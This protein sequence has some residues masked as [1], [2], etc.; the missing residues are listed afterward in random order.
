M[1]YSMSQK[2]IEKISKFIKLLKLLS[3]FT[4]V[5]S[6]L[7]GFY[8]YFN[9]I[10]APGLGLILSGLTLWLWHQ[11]K[12]K[13]KLPILT[14]GCLVLLIFV[15]TLEMVSLFFQINFWKIPESL[16]VNTAITFV[17]LSIALLLLVKNFYSAAQ[18]F[19]VMAFLI[20][21]IGFLG[22]VYQIKD[23]Y[24]FGSYTIM[25]LPT[26]IA[27]VLLSL[28]IL[29][30]AP[31]HGWIRTFTS[32]NAGGIMARRM[33]PIAIAMPLIV[34]WLILI[35]YRSNSYSPEIAITLSSLLN[36]IFF[37]W[38]IWCTAR[39]L[40]RIDSQR[41]QVQKAL[42]DN[43]LKF[44]AI[45]DQSFQFVALLQPNGTLIE[46]NQAALDFAGITSSDVVNKPF[47]QTRWWVEEDRL[48]TR[49]SLT[50]HEDLLEVQEQ[51][52]TA[53]KEAAKGALVRYEV[54]VWGANNQAA[55]IDFSLKPLRDRTGEVILL[56]AEGR[57]ISDRKQF[58][59]ALREREQFLASIYDGVNYI[60]CVVDVAE[61]GNIT[62]AGWNP[63]TEKIT[64]ISSQAIFGK[65]PEELFPP[66][67][68]NEFRQG[69]NK[70]LAAKASISY[71]SCT[72][73]DDEEVWLM[74][75]L[76]PLKDQA[77]KI[78]RIIATSTYITERKKAEIALQNSEAQF[79]KLAQQEALINR[80]A[81]QIRNSLDIDRILETTVNEARSLLQIDRAAF[82]W[83]H[84]DSNPQT[85]ECIKEA[86]NDL[87]P[88]ILGLY[89]ATVLGPL[90]EKIM[91]REIFQVDEVRTFP[92]PILREFLSELRYTSI[93]ILPIQTQSGKVGAF[94][95]GHT[96]YKRPF[97]DSEVELIEA[98]GVQLAIALN[99]A[100]LYAQSRERTQQLEIALQE[101][102]QTQTQL[103]QSEKMSSLGQMVAGV[104]HE[105]NNPV[106][107]IYGNIQPATDY[108]RDLLKLLELYQVHYPFPAQQIQMEAEAIDLEFLVEDLPKLLNSMKVGATRIKDIVQSLR[109]FS[110]LDEADMKVVN[111]HEGIDSTIM[112]LEH[113]LKAKPHFSGISVIKKY[114][115]LPLIE[116]YAGQLNQV[117]MNILANA[118]DALETQ[119]EPRN[120][121]ITTQ[122]KN[123][124]II[125]SIAD[126]GVGMPQDIKSKI[127]DPFFTTKSV[128]KGTGLGLSISHSIIVEKHNGKLK[129]NSQLGQG[130]EF[131]IEIPVRQ[132]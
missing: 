80:I 128:G 79:R 45:F 132:K 117:F 17:F 88:S 110:R 69:F 52:K 96:R 130:T 14:F 77:G 18:F 10:N 81:N 22:E 108:I 24:G 9:S 109:I 126:N 5:I 91:M 48:I 57:D 34:G 36:I 30:A 105:I 41:Q 74:A 115:K 19:G 86:K 83:Y 125:I 75:T 67:L 76:T 21:L 50:S 4:S 103:I 98:V 15:E 70:C 94:S 62:Y 40:T 97:T 85:W 27:I 122:V 72:N 26:S 84:Y 123:Q 111:I 53:I 11:E 31:E 35:G 58:E 42:Q 89:K 82:G 118:I 20:S 87:L 65:T 121:T 102:Q 90:C 33:S 37:N 106:S 47:W 93:L 7:F 120:I 28:G 23:F 61:N 107:F 12:V 8:L 39:F 64:G 3:Q 54:D 112:I 38:V 100:E 78:H 29:L 116:C 95:F 119:P 104:A 71:E 59:T 124:L 6:I 114:S 129:C 68:S 46:I 44:R 101:L 60:I 55:T 127:F 16:T 32:E 49:L 25:L 113:R 13:A 66:Q 2:D 56:I 63:A 51:L 1:K 43:E 99:Q 73:I 131:I 92:D